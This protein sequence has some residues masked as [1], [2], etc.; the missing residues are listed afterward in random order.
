M[1][2]K[3]LSKK[4]DVNRILVIGMSHIGALRR[5]L[6][7]EQ[8]GFIDMISLPARLEDLDK[9]K[10]EIKVWERKGLKAE[11]VC[12]S[13]RGNFHSQFGLLENPEKFRLGDAVAGSVPSGES[14]RRFIPRDMLR[15]HFREQ[16]EAHLTKWYEFLHSQ[17]PGSRFV[18]VC[19]P[20]PIENEAHLCA[21]P[22]I[23][24]PKMHLGIAPR[25][26]RLKIYELQTELYREQAARFGA[27]FLSPPAEALT[28]DGFLD[29]TYWH[30]DP[31]HAN[32]QYGEL[33]LKQILSL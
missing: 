31:T 20:P 27:V 28:A 14:D 23:F 30:L 22:G 2:S 5:A 8:A 7:A 21:H 18:H 13:I 32:A 10:G 4:S 15:A 17:F 16:L 24:A 33:V 26:L 9:R 3:F 6:T 19:A 1:F 25:D 29:R 12:L 11:V